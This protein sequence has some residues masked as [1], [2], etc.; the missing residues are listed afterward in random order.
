MNPLLRPLLNG[1]CV[2]GLLAIAI[3]LLNTL[4]VYLLPPDVSFFEDLEGVPGILIWVMYFSGV[5]IIEFEYILSAEQG[6]LFL[7]AFL[8][9]SGFFY[10]VSFFL[11]AGLK[12]LLF[13][14]KHWAD[15]VIFNQH[16]NSALRHLA[17]TSCFGFFIGI[18]IA[19]LLSL[20]ILLSLRF[21]VFQFEDELW[22][23]FENE[24][25]LFTQSSL[26]PALLFLLTYHRVEP[27]PL[28]FPALILLN[29]G[30]YAILFLFL[31][32]ASRYL[33]LARVW[34]NALTGK[35]PA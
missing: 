23:L 27:G 28:V 29:G 6:L 32:L 8:V 17:G 2:G 25:W 21:E 20:P 26:W 18:S 16:R 5:F 4:L 15:T 12:Q 10:A 24:L 3:T 22:L 31:G 19:I 1:C 14:P 33:G 13:K 34:P 11:V 35:S 30:T 7:M 9:G